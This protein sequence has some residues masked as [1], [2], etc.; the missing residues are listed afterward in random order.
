[1][2]QRVTPSAAWKAAS[3]RRCTGRHFLHLQALLGHGLRQARLY[4]LQTVLH[5][6]LGRNQ[7]EWIETFG[8]DVLPKLVR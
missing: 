4:R 1:M 6:D 2:N 8:R 3:N 7:R 5:I